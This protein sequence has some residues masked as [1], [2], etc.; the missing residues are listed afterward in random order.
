MRSQKIFIPSDPADARTAL[1]SKRSVHAVAAR[2][3]LHMKPFA[4]GDGEDIICICHGRDDGRELVQCDDCRTWY[5]LECLGIKEIADLGH[6]WYCH[7]CVT[8]RLPISEPTFAPVEEEPPLQLA[9]VQ[10]EFAKQPDGAPLRCT[11]VPLSEADLV[12]RL[13]ALAKL[14]WTVFDAMCGHLVD[15]V[16][17]QPCTRYNSQDRF[18]VRQL[19]VHGKNWIF[20]GIFDGMLLWLWPNKK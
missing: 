9:V 11:F 5:H 12:Q 6:P 8:L 3:R 15:A 14:E 7:N 19:D 17:F 16:A 4:D 1:L 2:R 18:V 20:M 10:V 13:K